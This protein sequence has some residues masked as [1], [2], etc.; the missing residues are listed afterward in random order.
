MTPPFLPYEGYEEPEDLG[1][2]CAAFS[3]TICVAILAG[4]F[5]GLVALLQ[6]IAS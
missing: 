1:W 3:V 6:W 5:G 2:G 4:L